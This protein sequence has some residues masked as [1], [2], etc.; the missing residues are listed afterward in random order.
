[1][2]FSC[3]LRSIHTALPPQTEGIYSLLSLSLFFFAVVYS[4]VAE[5]QDS[6]LLWAFA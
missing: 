4:T 5:E 3:D 1:M 6:F 2:I